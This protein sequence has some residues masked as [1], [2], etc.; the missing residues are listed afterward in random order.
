MIITPNTRGHYPKGYPKSASGGLSTAQV[1][2]L[3]Q[4]TDRPDLTLMKDAIQSALS[5]A[6]GY[7]NRCDDARDW[8]YARWPGQ[9]V[10]GRKWP[11]RAM[12]EE[13]IW[14]WVGAADVR[15]RTS[16]KCVGHERTLG[17]FGVRN[18]KIAAKASR[19]FISQRESQQNTILMNWMI[20]TH[21]AAELHR[22]FRLGMAWRSGYGAAILDNGWK[23]TRRLSYID[24]SVMGLQEF[25]NEPSVQQFMTGGMSNLPIGEGLQIT[26]IQ[27]MILDPAYAEDLAQVLRSISHDFLSLK[28]ARKKLEDLRDLRTVQVP[29]PDIFES[30]PQIIALRPM[31]D[32]IFPAGTGDLQTAPWISRVEFVPETT[33]RDRI[34][35]EKYSKKFVE[36]ALDRRGAT[37]NQSWTQ[38]T[39]AERGSRNTDLDSLVELHHFSSLVHD[40][41]VPVRFKTVFHM[42]IDEPAMHEPDG[43]EHG[44]SCFHVLRR[45]TEHRPILSSRG[46]PEIAYTWEQSIKRQLDGQS[47]RA[48]YAMRPAIF[49]TA[50]SEMLKVKA[51]MQPGAI[52]PMQRFG[53]LEK[54]KPPMWDPSSV[55][56]IDRVERLVEEHF[57]LFGPN[58]DPSLKKLRQEEFVDDTL[59]EYKPVFQQM[60]KNMRQ[61][62][63]EEGVAAVIGPTSRPFHVTR[64]ELR[65]E[66]DLSITVDLR[67]ADAEWLKEKIPMIAQVLQMDSI[68]VADKAIIVTNL[69]EGIDY[70][71]ADMAIK[72]QGS[73]TEAEIQDEQLKIDLILGSGQDQP[74]PKGGNYQ[75][76]LQTLQAKVQGFQQNPATMQIIRSNPKI[77]QVIITRQ[78]FYERQLQQQQNAQIGRMQV[79]TTFENQGPA[80]AEPVGALGAPGGG[81]YT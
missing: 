32:V 3:E 44:E 2:E 35:T 55:M 26:D 65:G 15:P 62:L 33:L 11:G 29:I 80:T 56:V 59:A 4:A 43:Y 42:D 38:I 76:R 13:D 28:E 75:L 52:I 34:V 10:D 50:Y 19:P 9:T 40:R 14:P 17:T 5:D 23:Q 6:A 66:F 31:I 16:E 53:T 18:M 24:V 77:M 1:S 63:P 37:A 27:S 68:G 54:D 60:R 70:S 21:M 47:D 8:W 48:D 36:D 25:V 39:A 71:F 30:R 69:L 73:A 67:N 64:A 72:D 45:E 41:G 46:I 58:I 74:L 57:A 20:F 79:G 78:A 12:G 7:L 61:L 51:A 22:E 81:S 49:T